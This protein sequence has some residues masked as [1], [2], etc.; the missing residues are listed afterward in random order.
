M[1]CLLLLSRYWPVFVEGLCLLHHSIED[2]VKLF[3]F[4]FL[5]PQHH[6]NG[7]YNAGPYILSMWFCPIHFQIPFDCP[8]KFP[9][10]SR[11]EM[12]YRRLRRQ[13]RRWRHKKPA[14]HRSALSLSYA[15]PPK[16]SPA[17]SL[18]S[19]E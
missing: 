15:C 5:S 3:G 10:R 6:F 17:E 18:S 13:A 14:P 2:K 16:A 9:L 4:D 19:P 1:H 12:A 11:R 8:A 7:S